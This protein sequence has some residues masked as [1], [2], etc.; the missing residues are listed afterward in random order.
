MKAAFLISALSIA[1]LS[2]PAHA[3]ER[4]SEGLRETI[5]AEIQKLAT[6]A[7]AG[8]AD[9]FFAL[10]SGSENLVIA[11][12]G[13]ITRGLA[14]VRANMNDLFVERGSYR[15]QIGAADVVKAGRHVVIAVAPCQF[16]AVGDEAAVRLTG[17]I[18][19]VFARN[20]FWQDY[21]VVHSHRST[22]RIGVAVVE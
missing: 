18:T 11:G 19:V 14:E 16:T 1:L 4:A 8:D 22:G 7:N 5:S 3:Q 20:W 12:D 9:A 2:T 10:T 21:K 13:R 6:A 15:W 17:A